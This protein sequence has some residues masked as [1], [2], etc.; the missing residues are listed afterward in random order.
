[1]SVMVNGASFS[2]ARTSEM[3]LI[4]LSICTSPSTVI[5]ADIR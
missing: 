5:L 2:A 1:M 4:A 3:N